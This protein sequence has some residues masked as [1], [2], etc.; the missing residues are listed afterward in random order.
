M[1]NKNTD[2]SLNKG[3]IISSTIIYVLRW[4]AHKEPIPV[5]LCGKKCCF[6]GSG[7]LRLLSPQST[8][9]VPLL[10]GPLVGD[11]LN[12]DQYSKLTYMSSTNVQPFTWKLCTALLYHVLLSPSGYQTTS[13]HPYKM[14]MRTWQRRGREFTVVGATQTSC[15]SETSLR[16]KSLMSCLWLHHK[17]FFILVCKLDVEIKSQISL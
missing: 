12:T 13:G 5:R 4:G 10:L 2:F 15:R 8:D 16:W 17:L 3:T 6:H 14:R 9:P 1:W 11:E 7:R